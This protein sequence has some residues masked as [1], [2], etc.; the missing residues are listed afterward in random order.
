[1]SSRPILICYDGSDAADH[2]IT[3]AADVLG[4]GPAVVLD[5]GEVLTTAESVAAVSSIVPGNAFEDLNT[6][7]ALDRARAGAEH[8]RRAGFEAKPRT[9]LQS[10]T[11]EGIVDVADEI[12]A[13]VIVIGTRALTG[14]HDALEG[15]VSHQVAQHSGRP[16]L[17]V[18]AVRTTR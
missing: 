11:W 18:P 13:P 16:V 14:V 4:P 6:A 7:D 10:P 17:I 12:D 1:M 2:A 8:A 3:A 15:S 5:V 9:E